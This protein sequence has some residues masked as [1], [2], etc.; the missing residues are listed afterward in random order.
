MGGRVLLDDDPWSLRSSRGVIAA[1]EEAL[2]NGLYNYCDP[3]WLKIRD[4]SLMHS[5]THD[6]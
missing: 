6:V 3:Q 2:F 4:V 5:H 1:E